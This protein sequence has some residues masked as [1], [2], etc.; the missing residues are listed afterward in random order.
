M[1]NF[2]D[3]TELA[4]TR[5]G[6]EPSGPGRTN[7]HRPMVRTHAP[8][9]I[10]SAIHTDGSVGRQV[11]HPARPFSSGFARSVGGWRGGAPNDV[12]VRVSERERSF[13]SEPTRW[14]G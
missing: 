14:A 10:A 11:V 1:M 3:F 6:S 2:T 12:N 9:Q 4:L 13:D 8:S 7:G 5:C